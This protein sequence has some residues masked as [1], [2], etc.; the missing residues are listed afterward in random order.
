MKRELLPTKFPGI[1]SEVYAGFWIRAAAKI[2][3]FI[4]LLPLV[5]ILLYVNG[6]S[7]SAYFYTVVPNLLFGVFFEVYLVKVYG[8]TPG[9]LIMD[10]KIIQKN[11]DDVN[12]NAAIYRY[13]V[14]F[15]LAVLGI[16][17]IILT[18]NSIDDS[19]Y[20][21]LGFTKKYTLIS[22]INPTLSE[23]QSWINYLWAISGTIVLLA[24]P[25]KRAIHD[26]IAGTVVIKSIYLDKI[27][28][29]SD[30]NQSPEI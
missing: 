18:L 20:A 15:C 29:S 10:I 8:G 11:G 6:L 9:K 25:R 19:Y 7:K 12:W 27:R 24:N 23:I 14:D 13:A 5:G 17:L 22:T 2:L 1:E 3:D 30:S 21:G 16:Y 28:E 4:I 26:F